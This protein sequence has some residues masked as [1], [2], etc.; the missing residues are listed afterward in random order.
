MKKI[1][2][3]VIVVLISLLAIIVCANYNNQQKNDGDISVK[4]DKTTNEVIE[5]DKKVELVNQVID[6]DN[7]YINENDLKNENVEEG[8]KEV[9]VFFG[10]YADGKKDNILYFYNNDYLVS[11]ELLSNILGQSKVEYDDKKN[12]IKLYFDVTNYEEEN[13]F[14]TIDMSTGNMVGKTMNGVKLK[15]EKI[16]ILPQIKN[17]DILLLL[18]CILNRV[19]ICFK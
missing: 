7:N 19:Q 5:I 17:G 1:I 11:A 3:F 16:S 9:S 13:I 12:V 15:D 4:E 8:M 14:L 18:K 10:L 6:T 2:C